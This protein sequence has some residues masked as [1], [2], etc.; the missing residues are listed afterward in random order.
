MRPN[1]WYAA[2][3]AVVVLGAPASPGHAQASETPVKRAF[4]VADFYRTVF[5][6]APGCRRTGRGSSSP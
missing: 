6:G 3:V 1:P 2:L 4:E 5:V